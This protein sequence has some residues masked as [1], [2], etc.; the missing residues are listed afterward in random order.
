MGIEE[1]IPNIEQKPGVFVNGL[2]TILKADNMEKLGYSKAFVKSRKCTEIDFDVL[3]VSYPH[4]MRLK[5]ALHL[6]NPN[7]YYYLKDM[8]LF[9][10]YDTCAFMIA[11]AVESY[12]ALNDAIEKVL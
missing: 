7:A 2:N 12:E 5:K 9:V 1:Y 3:D 4:F 11:P 10:E 8:P 6:R